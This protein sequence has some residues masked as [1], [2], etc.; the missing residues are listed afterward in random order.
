M[1]QDPGIAGL[2]PFQERWLR[3][4]A[5]YPVLRWPLT[6]YLGRR[7]AEAEGRPHPDLDEHVP[8]ARLDWFRLGLIPDDQRS[9]LVA[10]M[11]PRE[12]LV[13]R[14]AYEDALDDPESRGVRADIDPVTDDDPVFA[15]FMLGETPGPL[16]RRFNRAVARVY[17]HA[18]IARADARVWRALAGGGA[19]GLV[20]AVVA[21][22]ATAGWMA[23][24]PD[25][26][27]VPIP[28]MVM[29]PGG[30]FQMGSAETEVGRWSN[31]GPRREVT[32]APFAI[33]RTEVTV[34]QFA[35]FV[36]ATGHLTQG[37]CWVWS[38][39]GPPFLDDN[40]DRR[41]PGFDPAD[42][43]PVTCV[44]WQDA[45]AYLAWLS[46]QVGGAPFRL[47][48]EA[49]WEYA[50]R[51]GSGSAY[52]WGAVVGDVPGNA[53][54]YANGS[55]AGLERFRWGPGAYN[56]CDDE[57][58]FT[59]SVGSFLPNGFGLSDMAGNV[60]EWVEDCW[61]ENYAGAPVDGRAWLSENGGDCSAR[62]VR[63]GSWLTAPGSLRSSL[64]NWGEAGNRDGSRGFRPARTVTP[65]GFS[66]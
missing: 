26:K 19:L 44:S 59:A 23:P 24:G 38:G 21:T 32:V 63:G 42:D 31:E 54:H 15:Q 9:R 10:G 64:R 4:C 65:E 41:A 52:F 6:V 47:P 33:A 14:R 45:Q 36:E 2:T 60:W 53:C 51:G 20:A 1:D 25:S 16:E 29:L 43:H 61:H 58:A 35:A 50:A 48:T 3:A 39:A 12:R 56:V 34:A 66:P 40:A 5:V 28:Q 11:A 55:V 18:A 8:L 17:G 22:W 46:G 57:E 27:T 37:G 13:V 30:T 49:E 62:V 7:L